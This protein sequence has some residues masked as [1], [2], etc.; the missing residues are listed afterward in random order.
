MARLIDVDARVSAIVNTPS[1]VAKCHSYNVLSS[2]AERQHEILDLID[3][4]PAVEVPG[5]IPVMERLPEVGKRVI[6][7]RKD[8]EPEQGIYLGVNGW[9]KVFG[10]NTKAITHWMPMPEPPEGR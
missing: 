4:Q 8:K 10:A 2:L 9:W 5:W 6:V 1:E 3:E 7:A